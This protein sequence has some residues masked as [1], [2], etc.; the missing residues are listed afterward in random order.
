[1]ILDKMTGRE[2]QASEISIHSLIDAVDLARNLEFT[3][4]GDL[5][6]HT[7]LA[8]KV[9]KDG[10]AMLARACQARPIDR[11]LARHA[12]SLFQDLMPSDCSI[13]RQ[14]VRTKDGF[15]ASPALSNLRPS[16]VES[17]GVI[18]AVAYSQAL[19]ACQQDSLEHYWGSY[20][21]A[22]VPEMFVS[23]VDMLESQ[24]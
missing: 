4:I 15:S 8:R 18:G 7:L 19:V 6:R 9:S 14:V 3:T 20:N 24:Q 11:E 13:H 23:Y 22:R 17:F 1:M 21:W 12:L 16:F 5:L 10:L 2:E